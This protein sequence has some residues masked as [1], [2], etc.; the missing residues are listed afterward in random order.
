MTL[1]TRH[2]YLK[3]DIPDFRGEYYDK[4]KT[5]LCRG[6]R[7]YRLI[8]ELSTGGWPADPDLGL[9]G[10]FSD[11]PLVC[12][13][14][15]SRGNEGHDGPPAIYYADETD[16]VKQHPTLQPIQYNEEWLAA[17]PNVTGICQTF[18][19]KER[20]RGITE[21]VSS[22]MCYKMEKE[23]F[24]EEDIRPLDYKKY[25][26]NDYR[27]KG[28]INVYLDDVEMRRMGLPIYSGDNNLG[29]ICPLLDMA[30]KALEKIIPKDL[31]VDYGG[32]N[33]YYCD[34]HSDLTNANSSG[35]WC[36][37]TEDHG[38]PYDDRLENAACIGVGFIKAKGKPFAEGFE[39]PASYP[40]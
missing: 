10:G 39:R 23:W 35:N 7:L 24:A 5:V 15:G 4:G 26:D 27:Q 19:G 40:A 22:A 6:K 2:G 30:E 9:S 38:C 33:L 8:E 25:E 32:V 20:R 14:F 17:H 28:H 3:T 11:D 12:K 36:K 16:Y 31:P 1:H 13:Q 29:R 37:A 18:P 34:S 21:E